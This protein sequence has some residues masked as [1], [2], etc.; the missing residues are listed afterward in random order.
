MLVEKC[1]NLT[2][3][4]PDIKKFNEPMKILPYYCRYKA[5]SGSPE[6]PKFRQTGSYYGS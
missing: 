6:F 5:K 2:R 3:L 4:W 1:F